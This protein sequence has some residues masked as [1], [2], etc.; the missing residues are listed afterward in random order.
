MPKHRTSGVLETERTRKKSVS[1]LLFYAVLFCFSCGL[2]VGGQKRHYS[3]SLLQLAPRTCCFYNSHVLLLVFVAQTALLRAESHRVHAA[4]FKTDA[5]A[6]L[7]P[8]P[9]PSPISS[10]C[11]DQQGATRLHPDGSVKWAKYRCIEE[12][13]QQ[14]QVDSVVVCCPLFV[15]TDLRLLHS[16][17]KMPLQICQS[18]QMAENERLFYLR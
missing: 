3:S 15:W 16:T 8:P 1:S 11:T 18:R 10:V 2:C 14:H 5:A 13:S 12:S 9:T 6:Q 17:C 7:P 4:S